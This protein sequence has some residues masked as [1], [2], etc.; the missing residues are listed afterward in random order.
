VLAALV[1]PRAI[2]NGTVDPAG[3]RT[4]TVIAANVH[5][6]TADPAAAAMPTPARSPASGSSR[7]FRRK[8]T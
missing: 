3:H 6:G 2:G 7:P 5:P 4:I 1:L 8:G